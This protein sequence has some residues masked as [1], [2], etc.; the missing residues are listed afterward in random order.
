MSMRSSGRVV[1]GWCVVLLGALLQEVYGASEERR[2]SVDPDAYASK[3]VLEYF[4]SNPVTYFIMI[5]MV[6]H[7]FLG[8]LFFCFLA[9]ERS[10][11]KPTSVTL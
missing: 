11:M 8:V 7:V 1:I 5:W 4:M 9:S 10:M 3:T 6:V 2:L